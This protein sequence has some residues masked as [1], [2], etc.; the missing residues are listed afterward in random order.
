MR[1]FEVYSLKNASIRSKNATKKKQLEN[2]ITQFFFKDKNPKKLHNL[3]MA[4]TNLN[5]HL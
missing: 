3:H 1:K 5:T 2:A 4:I